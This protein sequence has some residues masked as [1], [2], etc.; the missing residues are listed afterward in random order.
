MQFINMIK[1][2]LAEE[3]ERP[4]LT[5]ANCCVIVDSTFKAA[6]TKAMAS[7]DRM[8]NVPMEHIYETKARSSK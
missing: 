3:I 2:A 8:I 5:N 4:N 1:V 6:L 7:F